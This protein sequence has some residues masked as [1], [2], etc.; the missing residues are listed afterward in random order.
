[1]VKFMMI[2]EF[3]LALTIIVVVLMQESKSDALSGLI[4]GSKTESF[5]SKNKNKTKKSILENI[6]WA[7]M[8]IFMV[9]TLLLN[10][11]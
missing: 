9:N 7:S 1:M 10:I 3:V 11:F 4:Q 8:A 2:L 5:Y 6:T